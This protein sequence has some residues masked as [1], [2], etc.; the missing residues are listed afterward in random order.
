MSQYINDNL[1]ALI[2]SEAAKEFAGNSVL[3]Q[4]GR[5]SIAAIIAKG[6]A[7]EPINPGDI[8]AAVI[9][10]LGK[11]DAKAQAKVVAEVKPVAK[12]AKI[13]ADPRKAVK[14]NVRRCQIPMKIG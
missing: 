8:Q 13:A 2:Q 1:F 10:L 7:G 3:D 14:G 12:I 9:A 11:Q 4:I 6:K 5:Q